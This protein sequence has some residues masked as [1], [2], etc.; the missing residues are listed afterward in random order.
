MNKPILAVETSQTS[1]SVSV[2]FSN[3]KYFESN[4]NLKHSHAEVLFKNIE[5][6]LSSAKINPDGLDYIAI[7]SGPG[8]F[9]GLRIGMAAVKG[10]AFASNLNILPVPTFDALAFQISNF[11]PN[12]T[13]FIIMNRVNTEEVY[14]EKF[15][16]SSNNY[17]VLE[18][19][20]IIKYDGITT[21][22]QNILIFGNALLDSNNKFLNIKKTVF[23][24]FSRFV[25]E[26]SKIYGEKLLT[27]DFDYLEPLYFKNFIVKGKHHV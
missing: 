22:K 24:P 7:S 5:Y 19:L 25:A 18:D 3:E 13:E 9:T 16:T 14:F 12:E 6:V 11:L 1:C 4:F 2:Y 23:S 26:W 10:I 15:Q 17:K 20:K 8:S 27:K 21:L